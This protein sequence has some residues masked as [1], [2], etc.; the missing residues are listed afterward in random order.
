YVTD[1]AGEI[2]DRAFPPQL[3][4]G[5]DG[6]AGE[7]IDST[8]DYDPA[9]LTGTLDIAGTAD[10]ALYTAYDGAAVD[11]DLAAWLGFQ[12]LTV[13]DN[14]NWIAGVHPHAKGQNVIDTPK[15]WVT[16]S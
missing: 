12:H 3:E 2:A 10:G 6:L 1:W 5:G 9:A 4:L 8:G 15:V 7:A 14:W 16:G 11:R 13:E